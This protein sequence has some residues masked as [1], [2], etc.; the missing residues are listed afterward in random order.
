MSLA[1]PRFD[2]ATLND[3]SPMPAL[4]RLLVT[5][6]IVVIKWDRYRQTRKALRGLEPHLLDDIGVTPSAARAEANKRFWQD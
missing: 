2:V 6:A 3:H 5:A 4:A 1:Q